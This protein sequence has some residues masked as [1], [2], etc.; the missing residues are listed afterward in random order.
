MAYGPDS[1]DWLKLA[2]G[3]RADMDCQMPYRP[4][5]PGAGKAEGNRID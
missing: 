2:S 5:A 1:G 4:G 3:I